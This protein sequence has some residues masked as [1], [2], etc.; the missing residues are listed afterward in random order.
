MGYTTKTFQGHFLLGV[1]LGKSYKPQFAHDWTK[2]HKVITRY[3]YGEINDWKKQKL[4]I[5]K[6]WINLILQN[7][8]TAPV[9][10][11]LLH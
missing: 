11:A 4:K 9:F 2:L 7:T 1:L 8:L 3:G 6:S 10:A 5:P